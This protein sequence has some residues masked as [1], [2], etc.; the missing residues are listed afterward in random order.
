MGIG[1][2]IGEEC[3]D[4]GM[5]LRQLSIK[6]GV[7]YST[8]YSAVKRDSD[9]I[10][11][12]TITRLANALEL[13]ISYFYSDPEEGEAI[14]SR[15]RGALEELALSVK[16]SLRKVNNN[17]CLTDTEVLNRLLADRIPFFAKK[18][19]IPEDLLKVDAPDYV[20]Q[21]LSDEQNRNEEIP[22]TMSAVQ[23]QMLKLMDT[24][25]PTGQQTA[26]ERIEELAQIPKYQKAPA[27]DSTQSAGTGDENDP[28]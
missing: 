13:P 9:G 3:K 14:I 22:L 4:A 2:R 12:G 7:P 23:I 28:E 18:F 6:S 27:G 24:M 10:D 26:V 15:E 20:K 17:D 16:C 5:T 8:L 21:F 1:K 19:L 25:N 11:A